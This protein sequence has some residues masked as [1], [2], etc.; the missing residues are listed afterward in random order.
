MNKKMELLE[1]N[2]EENYSKE[3]PQPYMDNEEDLRRE[4]EFED[5]IK[6]HEGYWIAKQI[7]SRGKMDPDF[8]EK[9]K[10]MSKDEQKKFLE[11]EQDKN[12]NMHIRREF[13]NELWNSVDVKD[14]GELF[15]MSYAPENVDN[16]PSKGESHDS[17]PINDDKSS[18]LRFD[19]DI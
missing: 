15:I 12:Q 14:D 2:G 19:G 17:K 5:N 7:V 8:E 9:Y 10:S 1:F 11:Q 4:A 16:T 3:D 13:N 18:I 6:P